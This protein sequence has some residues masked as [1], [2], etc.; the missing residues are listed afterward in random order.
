MQHHAADQLHIEMALAEGALGRLAYGRKGRNQ[1]VIEGLALGELLA[2]L[3]GARLE[4][5]IRQRRHLRLQ[6]VDGIDT[7]LIGLDPPVVG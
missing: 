1:D 2:E 4:R 7:W 5:L 6:G 3:D